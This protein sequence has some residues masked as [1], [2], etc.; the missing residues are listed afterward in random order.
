MTLLSR[1]PTIGPR[2]WSS[3][4]RPIVGRRAIS[5][6]LV[7]VL[8]G[9]LFATVPPKTASADALSDAYAQQKR[10]EGQIAAQK[11]AIATLNANQAALGSKIASTKATLGSVI[12]DLTAVKVD[13]VAMV[14]D[15][16][17]S[18]A[19]VDELEATVAQLDRELTDLEAQERAKQDELAARKAMLAERIRSA[20]DTDRTSLL[21]SLLSSEDF[22]DVLSEVS[23]HLD[24]ADQDKALADQ[25]GQDQQVLGVLHQTTDMARFQADQMRATAATQKANLDK[26]LADLAAAKAKLAALQKQYQDLLAAQQAAYVKIAANKA[27]LAAQ[28]H[29]EAVA[30]A[31]LQSVIDKLVLAALQQGGIPSSYSGSLHWPMPGYVSQP[32]GCT[33][34]Y[35]EPP[36]GNCAHFHTG[37]DIV[38]AAGTPI[39]AAGPG[40]VIYVGHA[41][42]DPAY[43]V[44]I[45]HSSALWTGYWHVQT[46][47]PVHVGQYVSTG[48]VIAYE[49]C[50]GWCTGPHL[51][52]SVNLNDTYVNPRLFL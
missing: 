28:L 26:Q 2:G 46:R 42:Y 45:A 19:A 47:I 21:Q 31:K 5:A 25:I 43:I 40:K 3:R 35:M 38:N 37:I 4:P 11:N 23:Y 9:G 27:Q 48:Q 20:Y 50:T 17:K 1:R 34:F 15:V 29:N 10:L 33:G 39:R 52:W 36:L 7:V 49:G 44:I 18:Q 51:H 6:L 30:A 8:A 32:F 13:L 12:S 24:F 41:P 22:T 16:A 14:V